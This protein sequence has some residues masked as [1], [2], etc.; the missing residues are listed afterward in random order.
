MELDYVKLKDIKP[1]LSGYITEAMS[2]LKLRPV[3]DEMAIHDV[4]VLMKK[5]R[6]VMRLI[7]SQI[8]EEFYNREYGTFREVG[9]IMSSW[10]DTSVHRKTL[11]YLKKNHPGLFSRLTDNEKLENLLGKTDTTEEPFTGLKTDLGQINDLLGKAGFRIR[12]QSMNNLDPKLLLSELDRSYNVVIDRYLACRNSMKPAD[13]HEFR[14]RAKDFLYQLWF[15]RPLNPR[16]VKS[17]EKRLDTLTQ[18]LGKYND[19]SQLILTID[20]RYTSSANTPALDELILIIRK[21]QDR[22]LSKVWVVAYKIFCPGQKLVN[23]LGF[24]VLMM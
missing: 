3:P 12:F 23:L 19:L 15:F 7:V 14:K 10:R 5:S 1:A 17:L 16:V 11:K 13:L 6:A 20:Y 8:D 21:V 2:L 18:N 4:R 9:R 22:Y 24:R